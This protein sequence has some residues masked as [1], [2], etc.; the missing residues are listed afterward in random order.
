MFLFFLLQRG[1]LRQ[2]GAPA[3]AAVDLLHLS[4]PL[5]EPKVAAMSAFGVHGTLHGGPRRLCP[6]TGTL[7]P[8]RSPRK[9]RHGMI[10][11]GRN[12]LCLGPPLHAHTHNYDCF[13]CGEVAMKTIIVF[14]GNTYS[15][16]V[17]LLLCSVL[18][19]C[20]LFQRS[21]DLS[22][23]SRSSSSSSSSSSSNKY[24]CYW[25]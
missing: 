15:C 23:R 20:E 5:P 2:D 6:S 24:Y 13:H 19:I 21:V 9:E 10:R 16:V 3:R 4:R 8:P 14:F 12:S 18:T 1:R 17:S 11:A 25:R 7:N 22:S